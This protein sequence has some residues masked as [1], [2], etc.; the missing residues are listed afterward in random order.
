[1]GKRAKMNKNRACAYSELNSNYLDRKE[2]HKLT[3]K[4]KHPRIIECITSV[5]PGIT[6]KDQSRLNTCQ[7]RYW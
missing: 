1:M 2:K 4:C 3:E 6:F 7:L 5:K